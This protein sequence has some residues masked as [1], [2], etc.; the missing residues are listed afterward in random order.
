MKKIV[1]SVLAFSLVLAV[2][3]QDIPER[4]SDAPTMHHRKDREGMRRHHDMMMK[5]LNLTDAQKEKF[6]EERE[7]F[8]KQMDELKKKDDITVKEWR[9][10]ME[11]L[12]K[13]H[14]SRIDGILTSEQKDRMEKLK[15]EGKARREDMM[16]RR[17]DEM[18]TRLGLS[19]EQ[20]AKMKKNHEEMMVKMKAIR[21]DKSLSDE[22][23]RE[24]V[25]ELMKNNKESL[26]SILTKEQLEKMKE[27]RK[28][29]P[30]NRDERKDRK[31]E[32]K[33]TI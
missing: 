20:S 26:K 28:D 7:S 4:K 32:R 24:A 14:K 31:P 33:E 13:E 3:A 18:K 8:R 21:D 15:E 25:K 6:K 11:N 10:R 19:E 1:L 23:K 16:K 9:S 17:G 30:K 12:H 22:K 2:K 5:D 27:E 29:M